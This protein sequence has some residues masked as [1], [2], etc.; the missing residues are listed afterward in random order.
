[1]IMENQL[2][3]EET[4][5][6]VKNKFYN[7]LLLTVTGKGLCSEGL[8]FMPLA[9]TPTYFIKTVSMACRGCMSLL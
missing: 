9:V 7:C 2:R 5:Q 1:M 6:S 3:P 4:G 8:R